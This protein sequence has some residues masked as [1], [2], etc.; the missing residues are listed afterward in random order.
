MADIPEGNHNLFKRE[1]RLLHRRI[2]SI[3]FFYGGAYHTL[4][5]DHISNSW[6]QSSC[7]NVSFVVISDPSMLVYISYPP[8]GMVSFVPYTPTN[9]VYYQN[10]HVVDYNYV[11][12]QLPYGCNIPTGIP[13]VPQPNGCVPVYA[14]NF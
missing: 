3:E 7:S 11:H 8:P 5:L 13:Y 1:K 2:G 4:I 14:S 12:I 9:G 10:L 6:Y